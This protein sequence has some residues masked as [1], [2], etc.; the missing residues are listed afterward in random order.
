[1]ERALWELEAELDVLLAGLD[2]IEEEVAESLA[3][4]SCP[5]TLR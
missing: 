5:R 2:R 1:M 3:L 4:V